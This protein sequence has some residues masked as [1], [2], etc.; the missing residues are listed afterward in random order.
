MT[1]HGDVA[2]QRYK[3]IFVFFSSANTT[4]LPD[5]MLR[6]VYRTADKRTQVRMRASTRAV[7]ELPAPGAVSIS[8][9]KR[10]LTLV[11]RGRALAAASPTAILMYINGDLRKMERILKRPDPSF[12]ALRDAVDTDTVA[13]MR[14]I[15][16]KAARRAHL[17]IPDAEVVLGFL[18]EVQAYLA[19]L[20]KTV[21]NAAMSRAAA[22]AR[23]DRK[24]Y[25]RDEL[26]FSSGGTERRARRVAGRAA[27]RAS[28]QAAAALAQ[29]PAT[30]LRWQGTR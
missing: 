14:G 19:K 4:M 2:G 28:G 30:R 16:I 12:A 20:A 23:S 24:L 1:W 5:N 29:A 6:R 27:R 10:V 13:A 22:L 25:K 11:A 21:P 7:H 26:R 18:R 15:T 17:G 3:D 9:K 8:V